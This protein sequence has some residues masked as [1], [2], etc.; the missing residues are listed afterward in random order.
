MGC[1]VNPTQAAHAVSSITVEKGSA[2]QPVRCN[3]FVDDARGLSHCGHIIVMLHAAHHDVQRTVALATHC[4]MMPNATSPTCSLVQCRPNALIKCAA[5]HTSLR[6][7]PEQ[8]EER[9]LA[10]D[11]KQQGNLVPGTM[12]KKAVCQMVLIDSCGP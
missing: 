5:L 8:P 4:G 2:A 11:P 6:P 10:A 9:K 7:H 12:L 3:A 1:V